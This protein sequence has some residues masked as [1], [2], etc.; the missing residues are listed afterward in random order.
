MFTMGSP[1]IGD[2]VVLANTSVT[3]VV[4]GANGLTV[5]S[6][7]VSNENGAEVTAIV[8][9]Y[10]G[11]TAYNLDP[12]TAIPDDDTAAFDME[13]WQKGI[14]VPNGWSIRVTAAANVTVFHTYVRNSTA[15]PPG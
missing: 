9:L 8:D 15:A 12:G 7:Q 11:S 2:P 13:S 6:L 3:T 10:D 1:M 14:P 4:T 5:T